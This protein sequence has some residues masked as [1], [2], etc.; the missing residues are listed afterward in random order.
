MWKMTGLI[1]VALMFSALGGCSGCSSGGPGLRDGYY[2][3]EAAEFDQLGWKEFLTI[4]VNNNII[5]TAGY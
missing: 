1:A 3:A 2:T 5:V 4:Y